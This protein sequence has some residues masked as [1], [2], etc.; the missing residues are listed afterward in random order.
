MVAYKTKN[1][2]TPIKPHSRS[3][4]SAVNNTVPKVNFNSTFFKKSRRQYSN[5]RGHH[6]RVRRK[7]DGRQP[8]LRHDDTGCSCIH[9]KYGVIG[10]T[11][12]CCYQWFVTST[13]RP[14]AVAAILARSRSLDSSPSI[15][16][17]NRTISALAGR[18]TTEN[19]FTAIHLSR[20]SKIGYVISRL[21]TAGLACR[22]YPL[23]S[24]LV[25]KQDNTT[26]PR[27]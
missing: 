18:I 12:G 2:W 22:P 14:A 23:L 21:H 3:D 6:H 1:P 19:F 7:E 16:T 9:V 27:G 11:L 5:G 13:I 17:T 8:L 10:T 24:V 25:E 15:T 20:V 4:Q 26:W